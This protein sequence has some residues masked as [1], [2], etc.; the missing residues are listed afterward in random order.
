M[1]V[2]VSDNLH[3]KA[4]EILKETRAEIIY[5]PDSLEDAIADAE[6]LVVRSATKVTEDLLSR[7]K[8]LK[9]V[10]RGGVGLDNIDQDACRKRN[11]EVLNTPAASTNAVAELTLA[12]VLS[13]LRNIPRAHHSMKQG[14]W[15]KKAL[16]GSEIHGKTLGI[17]GCGRIGMLAADKAH[18][19]GMRVIGY[20]PP[21]HQVSSFLEYVELD[22]LLKNADIISLHVPLLPSTEKMINKDSIS[23]MKDGAILINTARGQI[24][25]EDALYDACKSGKIRAAAIDVYWKEPYKG[26]LLE[27]ENVFLSPHI[28]AATEEAQVRIGE[29]IA[30]KIRALMG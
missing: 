20:N 28:A 22:D 24:I 13:T 19:L 5:K 9:A 29:E 17:I 30:A 12:L 10:M 4:L 21:P 3:P 25:D 23:K 7:A 26:K 27:L 1:K 6:L 15:E 11:I 18:K 16:S 2:V 8:S 14:K